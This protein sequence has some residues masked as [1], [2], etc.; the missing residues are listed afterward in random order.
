MDTDNTTPDTADTATPDTLPPIPAVCPVCHALTYDLNA[1]AGYHTA[2]ANADPIV[3]P[4]PE[5]ATVL[6]D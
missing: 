1:H 2:V 4:T 6:V 5:D 3:L